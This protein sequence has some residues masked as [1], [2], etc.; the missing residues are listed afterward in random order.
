MVVP[1]VINVRHDLR[2]PSIPREDVRTATDYVAA[3]RQKNDIIVVNSSASYAFGYYW[4]IGRPTWLPAPETATEFRM[5]FP[6]QPTIVFA[7][8]RTPSAVKVAVVKA[9]ALARKTPGARIWLVRMLESGVYTDRS[10]VPGAELN[11][12]C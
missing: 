7:L 4:P 6:H 1:F 10:Q 8:D 5:S 2:F 9:T 11:V 12:E 3:N